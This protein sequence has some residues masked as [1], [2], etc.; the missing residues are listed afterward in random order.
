MFMPYLQVDDAATVRRS[1]RRV[2][3]RVDDLQVN[4]AADDNALSAV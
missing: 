1:R 4:R 2:V 3:G